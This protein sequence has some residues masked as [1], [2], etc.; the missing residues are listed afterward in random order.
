MRRN[1][2]VRPGLFTLMLVL[3]LCAIAYSHKDKPRLNKPVET[4]E[5]PAA[6]G[7][8]TAHRP[9]ADEPSL[10][11]DIGEPHEGFIEEYGILSL[12]ILTALSLFTTIGLA[13]FR[14]KFGGWFKYHRAFAIAT[15]SLML[16]HAIV[17]I[18]E[19]YFFD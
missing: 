18:L 12:G 19:H 11:G 15:V 9:A 8:D 7:I 17:A 16:I 14:R 2:L 5:T 1:K 13:L 3:S 10:V 6:G 4:V